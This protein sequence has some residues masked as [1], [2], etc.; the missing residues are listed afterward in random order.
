MKRVP[1]E[2]ALADHLTKGTS[3]CE[4]DELIRRVWR[5][6]D[7]ESQKHRTRTQMELNGT[8]GKTLAASTSHEA[9]RVVS[10][11]AAS[12]M[13]FPHCQMFTCSRFSGDPDFS[14]LQD[15]SPQRRFRNTQSSL[16]T[17]VRYVMPARHRS[18]QFLVTVTTDGILRCDAGGFQET[19]L[20]RGSVAPLSFRKSVGSYRFDHGCA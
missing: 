13:Q 14:D 20:P 15:T 4:V 10:V 8:G 2:Q 18:R 11:F 12:A 17:H 5:A 7:G 16:K 1:G 6:S 19:S 3:W 9:G